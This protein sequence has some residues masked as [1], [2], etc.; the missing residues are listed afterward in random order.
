MPRRP[1]PKMAT[2]SIPGPLSAWPNLYRNQDKAQSLVAGTEWE[3][4]RRDL[5]NHRVVNLERLA[6]LDDEKTADKIRGAIK[7]LDFI[8]SLPEAVEN[9]KK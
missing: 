4:L 3:L 6:H 8:L 9:W 2:A 7:C 5:L 1:R